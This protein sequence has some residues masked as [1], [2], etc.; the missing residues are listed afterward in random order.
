MTYTPIRAIMAGL[1]SALQGIDGLRV[2]ADGAIVPGQ[3]NPPEGI[4]GIPPIEDYH[5]TFRMGSFKTDMPIWVLVSAAV[6]RVGQL[7][8]ADYADPSGP[9]S[10]R[11]ALET[12]DTA[13]G[14]STLGGVVS[15]LAVLSFR[16]LGLEEVGAIG[17]FGGV[18]TVRI[19]ATGA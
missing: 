2:N 11:A 18:W 14:R 7:A 13:D 1:A 3:I 16:P 4:I 19:V 6:D 5:G 9:K 17:Y 12:K 8:L 10:V 15:D